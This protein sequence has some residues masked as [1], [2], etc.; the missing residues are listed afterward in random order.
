M[1]TAPANPDVGGFTITFNAPRDASGES[2]PVEVV[3]VQFE[4][5][6]AGVELTLHERI[7]H[8][9]AELEQFISSLILPR[10][11]KI[12]NAEFE[13][14]VQ[15][16]V[17]MAVEITLLRTFEE[18]RVEGLIPRKT[19]RPIIRTLTKRITN[20]LNGRLGATRGGRDPIDATD[21]E[22]REVVKNR[23]AAYPVFRSAKD[24]LRDGDLKA[25]RLHLLPIT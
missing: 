5:W 7:G 14:E 13:N 11:M 4:W 2:A 16:A 24:L 3:T 20:M 18:L 6:R 12:V 21:E 10:A 23:D 19:T 1:R 8:A 25:W 9:R 17:M 15:L 22:C